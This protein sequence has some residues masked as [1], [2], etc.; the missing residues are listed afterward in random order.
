MNYFTLKNCVYLNLWSY[1]WLC[2]LTDDEDD[3]P[4]ILLD[5]DPLMVPEELTEDVKVQKNQLGA[6]LQAILYHYLALPFIKAR[7]IIIGEF[8]IFI[9][10]ITFLS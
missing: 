10:Q 2:I 5:P 1:I 6:I 9:I 3:D 7:W 8:V 4:M